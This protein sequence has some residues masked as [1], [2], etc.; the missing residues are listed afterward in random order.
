MKDL[1]TP[2][3]LKALKLKNR[4][5]MP[6][7]CQYS[8]SNK[9]GIA[10]DWHY[11]H[12]VSRAVGGA[13]LI[14]IEMTDVDPDGRITDFDL[15]IWSDEHIPALARIVEACHSYGAKVGIQIAH[16]GRKAEDAAVPVAPSAIP[17]NTESKTPRELSTEEVKEM[18]EKF[19]M[20]VQRAIKAGVDVIELH[21]AHGY[22]I[23]EFHS[24]LTN[25]R[26]D[27]YGQNLNLFGEE[28]IRAAKSEMPTGMPLI[29]RI[30]AKEYVE[31]GYG[32]NESLEFSKSYK[33]AGADMFHVSAGGEGPIAAAGKPGTHA[34]Y[35]VSLAREIKHN[36]KVPVIAVGRLDEAVLANAVIGNEDADLVA[37]GRG[38]LRNPYWALEAA[39]Q[40]HKETDIPKQYELGYPRISR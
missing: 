1:F 24:P 7:M 29:M 10:T 11:M 15:G 16:A 22:L 12:Y 23:H 37:V 9:D 8:V 19:R 40:L 18:V 31:G 25:R 3:E 5:V 35:Q 27:V 4:V 17:F 14:I 34:A 39:V 20:G 6:P 32:I 33:E 30:S 38:M 21:G 13:G 2:Y 36:L 28:V 26:K